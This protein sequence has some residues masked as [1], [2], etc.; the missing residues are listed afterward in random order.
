MAIRFSELEW[1]ILEVLWAEAP[2]SAT[3]VYERVVETADCTAKSVRVLM[4]RLRA[5]NAVARERRHGVWV[6]FPAVEKADCVAR[7]SATF[8]ERF[9]AGNAV[10]LVAH[11]VEN[12]ALSDADIAEL[13]AL[14][15]KKGGRR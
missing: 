15:E 7:E 13:R 10:P 14:L 11:L 9:F 1:R 12:E 5:K 8:L 4:D 6:F 2:L 3:E